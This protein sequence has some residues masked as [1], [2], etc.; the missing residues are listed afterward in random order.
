M[1]ADERSGPASRLSPAVG[2]ESVTGSATQTAS[3][4]VGAL[5]LALS[6]S[7]GAARLVVANGED[8]DIYVV[9]PTTLATWAGATRRLLGL[10]PALGA[11]DAVEYR[12]PFLIDREGRASIAFE[13]HVAPGVVTYRLLVSGAASRVAGLMTNEELVRSLVDAA[14]GAVSLA[15]LTPG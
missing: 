3:F 2:T 8:R 9:E 13:G 5:E 6:A 1:A 15:R 12:G 11:R 10:V 7:P 14:A 4:S